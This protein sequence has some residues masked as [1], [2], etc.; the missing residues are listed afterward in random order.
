MAKRKSAVKKK[1][2]ISWKV[3]GGI[4]ALLVVIAIA[5][6]GRN[7]NQE[8]EPTREMMVASSLSPTE[9]QELTPTPEP[10]PTQEP[11]ETP[12]PTP[13]PY[14]VH[15]RAPETTVYVSRNGV[16]HSYSSCSGMKYYTE[17]SIEEADA[18]GYKYCEHCW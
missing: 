2:K 18:G 17:M 9:T 8:I 13:T 14:R 4:L 1:A 11:T 5:G 15:G 3:W 10:T 12:E 7:D 16:I 6:G